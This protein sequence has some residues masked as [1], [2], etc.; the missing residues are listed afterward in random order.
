MVT[1]P[2]NVVIV[3]LDA[4]RADFI[5]CYG[6][7]ADV[8]T[9]NLDALA[10]D[11][12]RFARC[13]AASG[14]TTS[15][16]ASILTGLYPFQHGLRVCYADSGF[17]L[18]DDVPFLPAHLAEMGYDTAAFIGSFA[19]SDYYRFD[20]GFDRFDDGMVVSDMDLAMKGAPGRVYGW[21]RASYQRR[22]D[23]T[24]E[25]VLG[26]LQG[27]EE[28]T[29]FL[30]WV[31]YW[32]PQ[33]FH[34]AEA[35]TFPRRSF[36]HRYRR[37]APARQ[38]E[39][40]RM[41]YGCEVSFVDQQIGRLV[42][43]LREA[44]AYDNTLLLVVGAGGKGNGDHDWPDQELLYEEQLH[45]P[46]LIRGPGWQRGV[47]VDELTRTIDVFPTVLRQLNETPPPESLGQPLQAMVGAAE[48]PPRAAYAESLGTYDF[49]SWLSRRRPDDAHLYSITSGLWK[50]IHHPDA[51]DRDELYHLGD[52]PGETKNRYSDEEEIASRLREQL[53]ALGAFRTAPFP[54]VGESADGDAETSPGPAPLGESKGA[55]DRRP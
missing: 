55:G 53:D 18:G 43:W 15:S 38:L 47:V 50:L 16:H 24:T 1:R 36:I 52:D 10:E 25:A 22:S 41:M 54:A 9:P 21:Y 12:V 35:I 27:R 39:R 5:G 42:E 44:G 3:T 14:N 29:P 30:L 26:W 19:T 17:R 6:G 11:G 51:G 23:F 45:V 33:E 28:A 2:P 46:L 4:V 37:R 13:S 48:T 8:L 32:D 20:R 40:P 34:D 31:H 49:T 7:P